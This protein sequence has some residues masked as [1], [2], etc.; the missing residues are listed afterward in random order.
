MFL[1]SLHELLELLTQRDC[2]RAKNQLMQLLPVVCVDGQ[3]GVH[4][5]VNKNIV[6]HVEIRQL[7]VPCV[8][9]ENGRWWSPAAFED[10]MGWMLGCKTSAFGDWQR[11]TCG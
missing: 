9:L 3:S 4:V 6:E 1:D 11:I 8:V 5:L 2:L 7:A 10:N